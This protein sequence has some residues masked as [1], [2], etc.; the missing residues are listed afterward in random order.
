MLYRQVLIPSLSFLLFYSVCY[1]VLLFCVFVFL[2]WF[3][4]LY[5]VSFSLV[6]MEGDAGPETW[7]QGR[8]ES[9]LVLAYCGVTE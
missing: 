1:F 7:F 4:V 2:S 6:F 9:D 5:F 8:E 3:L